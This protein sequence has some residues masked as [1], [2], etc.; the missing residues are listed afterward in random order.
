MERRHFLS[1]AAMALAGCTGSSDES[2]TTPSTSTIAATTRRTTT[3]TATEATT[4]T[5]ETTRSLPLEV[6]DGNLKV[7]YVGWI[8]SSHLRYYDSD[9]DEVARL[10]PDNELWVCLQ[11]S[12]RN[13]GGDSR[14]TPDPANLSLSV[15]DRQFSPISDYPVSQ[16][17]LRLRD[18][19]RPYFGFP[20]FDAPNELP[21]GE[22]EH[23]HYIF[24][25]K[26]LKEAVLTWHT[27]DETH[28]L[29]PNH[30]F[31]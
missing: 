19:Q 13:L 18:L 15:S 9:S 7:R 22:Q 2:A 27:E 12:V 25:I 8:A 5:R 31:G 24:D 6:H 29:V 10:Q 17:D 20:S 14:M 28:Q 4:M 21:P 30:Y 26:P 11:L 3:E 23:E 16:T 1:M